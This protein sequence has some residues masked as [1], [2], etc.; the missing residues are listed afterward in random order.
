[1]LQAAELI[2]P[3]SEMLD[4]LCGNIGLKNGYH[5]ADVLMCSCFVSGD[6]NLH[7]N[8]QQR[9]KQITEN[10]CSKTMLSMQLTEDVETYNAISRLS[11]AASEKAVDV[12]R[13]V[14]SGVT[15]F[16]SALARFNN[17]FQNSSFDKIRKLVEI[18][19]PVLDEEFA[20][21]LEF[22]VAVACYIRLEVYMEKRG[23][24]DFH[25]SVEDSQQL[26]DHMN[27]LMGEETPVKFF[28]TVM[29]LQR[30]VCDAIGTSNSNFVQW[31][32]ELGQLVFGFKTM[33]LRCG[34]Q[35]RYTKRKNCADICLKTA[36]E[37]L[38]ET[39]NTHYKARRY[40]KALQ[41][42]QEV[43]KISTNVAYVITNNTSIYCLKMIGTCMSYLGNHGYALQQYEEGI[44]TRINE[45]ID[46]GKDRLLALF[47][48]NAGIC[49]HNL[50]RLKEA[51][52]KLKIAKNIRDEIDDTD[53]A[54]TANS[55]GECLLQL[56]EHEDALKNFKEAIEGRQQ[57]SNEPKTDSML[58]LFHY[59]AGVCLHKL[60]RFEEAITQFNIAKNIRDEIDDSAT[61]FTA[62]GARHG[63][64][65]GNAPGRHF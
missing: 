16:I 50:G 1:M 19:K 8:F 24:E 10:K 18:E 3:I 41:C 14:Y 20:H 17:I 43:Y 4:Y 33:I 60:E 6:K 46:R 47:N 62:P 21:N 61:A 37:V 45:T 35:L 15:L 57:Q 7:T 40:A 48:H 65:G 32:S 64:R 38:L 25:Y 28:T 54:S 11:R 49:L 2:K 58:A 55:F 12:K 31:S 52:T 30:E 22:A 39:G 26:T 27:Q 51:I 59:N 53:A 56:K 29:K 9:T 34:K 36:I 44:E 63:G 42:F 5:L 13:I 23:Q